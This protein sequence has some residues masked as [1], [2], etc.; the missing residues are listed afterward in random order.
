MKKLLN[1]QK[2]VW[3]LTGALLVM[4]ACRD[5]TK[6]PVL[7]FEK[8]TIGA[9]PKLVELIT[10]EYDLQNVGTTAFKYKIAFV[11]K[12][13]GRLVT[14][15]IIE[16]AYAGKNVQKDRTLYKEIESSQFI[17]VGEN[18]GLEITI[19]L[20]DIMN[21]FGLNES[22]LVAGDKVHF[23]HTVVINDGGK[24]YSYSAANSSPTVRGRA[25]QAF[26]TYSVKLTCPLPDN[27]F[28]G[29]Y[30][31]EYEDTVNAA[32]GFG[33]PFARGDVMIT[34]VPG[35]STKRQFS[36][37][38]LP[39]VVNLGATVVFDIVC[40][41]TV[42]EGYDSGLGCGGGSVVIGPGAPAPIDINDD[43]E[44]RINIIDYFKD[45][46]CGVPQIPKT[47]ILTKK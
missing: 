18:K 15:Y 35:S 21:L 43:S 37:I 13:K 19:P 1:M 27:I 3:A 9:Y 31:L 5:E 25:F 40:D 36:S 44:I 17:D 32:L 28:V 6:G 24:E 41:I 20:T 29:L 7:T 2:W 45:G 10:G 38:W 8:A 11:D 39:G 42:F 14:K 12:D 22:D 23:F 46:G 33:Y 47:I 30:T 16:A 34:T 26:F 4:T